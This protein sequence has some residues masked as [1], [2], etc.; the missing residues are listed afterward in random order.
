V[1]TTA[2][3]LLLFAITLSGRLFAD[4]TIKPNAEIMNLGDIGIY[5]VGYA[6][7]GQADHYLPPGWSGSEERTGMVYLPSGMQNGKEAQMLHVPWRNGTGIAFQDFT[8]ELP[9]VKRILVRGNIAMH[10][11]VVGKS[12]GVTFRVFADGHK[13]F[14]L[15][16]K[17]DVWYP[18][19]LDLSAYMGKKV[20]VRFETDPGTQ[21]NSNSDLALWGDRELVLEGFQATPHPTHMPPVLD[22]SKLGSIPSGTQAPQSGVA[23]T[24]AFHMDKDAAV[25][26]YEGADGTME[27][28]WNLP[29]KAEFPALGFVTLTAKSKRD[30]EVQLPLLSASMI[31]WTQ[32]VSPVENHWENITPDSATCVRTF[33]AG[34]ESATVKITGKLIGKSLI[35]DISCDKPWITALDT[36]GWGP[37]LTHKNVSVPYYIGSHFYYLPYENLFV[38]AYMDTTLSSAT[39]LAEYRARYMPL[40]DGTRNC[41]KERAICS[42][43]WQLDEILPNIPNPPSP[44]MNDLKDRIVLD[45]WGG[46]FTDIAAKLQ[47]LADYGIDKCAVIIHDWQ[48]SGYDNALPAHVPASKALGGEAGI[49][50]LVNTARRLGYRIALHE[51]Y[52]D[53]YPNYEHFDQNDITL[54]SQGER[55]TAWYNEWTKIQSFAVKP[56]AMLRLAETQSPEIDRR[57]HTNASF[58]DVNS[59]VVPWWHIDQNAREAGAGMLRHRLEVNRRLWQFERDTHNGPILGEGDAHWYWSGLLDGVEAQVRYGVDAGINTPMMVDF[60]LLKIHPLQFNHGMGYYERWNPNHENKPTYQL[61]DQYRMQEVAFGHAGFLGTT[62]TGETGLPVWADLPSAWLEHNLLVPVMERYACAKVVSIKYRINGDWVD[63]TAAVKAQDWGRVEV[64]YNNGLT[65]TACNAD[66]MH[67]GKYELPKFG[68]SATGAGVTAFTALL[69][70]SLVDYAETERAIFA[71][72]RTPKTG[73]KSQK[74]IDFGS[75]RTNGSIMIKREAKTWTLRTL[76]RDNHFTIE[77]DSKRFP[78]PVKVKSIGGKSETAEIKTTADHWSITPNGAKEYVW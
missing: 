60:D 62:L 4:T 40:T 67:A 72:V 38:A 74:I 78:P 13:L 3:A 8:F 5:E 64:K 52:V 25:F 2:L 57:Y 71:N 69:D 53:Y 37:V 30:A 76:H 50:T 41:L 47:N 20:V 19:E 77:L 27:Y 24:S 22:M 18:F 16:K 23:G 32:N 28:R 35:F 44:Y 42:A 61:L 73:G 55:Q 33:N 49:K 26:R 29:G 70:D 54:D 58:L 15:N 7:R 56:N 31:M 9:S 46:Q 17:D 14:E 34:R 45:I 75:V 1:K 51:N 11:D 6:Y 66:G 43:S 21:D 48:R 68:W 59:S 65:I 36:G 39:N 63:N 10:R 12:D